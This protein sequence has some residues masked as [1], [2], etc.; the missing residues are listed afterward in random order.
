MSEGKPEPA[1]GETVV[2][3]GTNLS[4]DELGGIQLVEPATSRGA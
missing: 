3:G 1:G 2:P 4:L